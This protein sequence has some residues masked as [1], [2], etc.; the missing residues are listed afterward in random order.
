MGY[1][2][3][4]LFDEIVRQVSADGSITARMLA[5][6]DECER[7]RPHKDWMSLRAVDFDG[8]TPQLARWL[9]S[10]FG[11]ATASMKVKGLWFGLFNPVVDDEVS[12]NIYVAGSNSF[13][14]SGG[15]W[16]CDPVF[17]PKGRYFN[18][19]VLGRIYRIAYAAG[20]GLANDAEHPLVIA[21]GAMLARKALDAVTLTGPL[22]SVEGVA[23]GFD[24]GDLLQL[25]TFKDGKLDLDVTVG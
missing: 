3:D 10:A 2:Y 7:Q 12:S 11:E 19:E 13:D 1:D 23:V 9:A 20:D 5:V 21:C 6:I 16:A 25:G 4:K 8:D 17:F 22:S 15:D 14:P 24:D 18:S